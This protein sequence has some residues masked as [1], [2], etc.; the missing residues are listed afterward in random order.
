MRRPGTCCSVTGR[1]SVLAGVLQRS[2]HYHRDGAKAR[3]GAVLPA[4]RDDAWRRLG[5][6]ASD[7][8]SLYYVLRPFESA[9]GSHVGLAALQRHRRSREYANMTIR[10]KPRPSKQR[11]H[12]S[13]AGGPSHVEELPARTETPRVSVIV[14]TFRGL[15]CTS[16]AERQEAPEFE[17]DCR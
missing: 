5:Q 1:W 12:L 6:P 11:D 17:V 9:G 3:Q 16:G 7:P 14:P 13:A 15:C 2:R 4:L 10:T 8:L